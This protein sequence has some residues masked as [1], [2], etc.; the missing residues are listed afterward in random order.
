MFLYKYTYGV[1]FTS[2]DQIERVRK[3][4]CRDLMWENKDAV[5]DPGSRV[6][7]QCFAKT[8][9]IQHRPHSPSYWTKKHPCSFITKGQG[10][11]DISLG[12][13]STESY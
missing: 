2:G 1:K 7:E 9:D 3:P 13:V 6:T 11:G 12:I 10:L 5:D 4:V 8:Q